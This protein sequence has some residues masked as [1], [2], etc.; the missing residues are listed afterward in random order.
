M[1]IP[2]ILDCKLGRGERASS[3]D[4]PFS[5]RLPTPWRSAWSTFLAALYVARIQ[6]ERMPVAYS[7]KRGSQSV[8]G[9][10]VVVVN[11]QGEARACQLLTS[12][13]DHH[14]HLGP[15]LYCVHYA[16][17]KRSFDERSL[18]CA[19]STGCCGRRNRGIRTS[20]KRGHEASAG[21][22]GLSRLYAFLVLRRAQCFR[23]ILTV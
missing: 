13:H 22:A 9:D 17:S 23:N 7:R 8:V 21:V 16:S 12:Y 4:I 20:S 6:Y 10:G 14:D 11:G 5:P 15:H 19:K 2:I 18:G 3:E 1:G